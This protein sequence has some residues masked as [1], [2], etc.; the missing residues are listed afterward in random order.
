M[1]TSTIL[2]Q[3]NVDATVESLKSW[4]NS[5]FTI[6]SQKIWNKGNTFMNFSCKIAV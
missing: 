5:S 3:Q 2:S 4:N 1:P 6:L